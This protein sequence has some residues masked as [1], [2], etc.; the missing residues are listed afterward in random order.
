MPERTGNL[1][2]QTGP[3]PVA[4]VIVPERTGNLPVTA[5]AVPVATGVQAGSTCPRK[6]LARCLALVVAVAVLFWELHWAASILF[7]L[8]SVTIFCLRPTV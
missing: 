1:P 6:C 8:I 4:T 3:S 5:V 2:D 7:D